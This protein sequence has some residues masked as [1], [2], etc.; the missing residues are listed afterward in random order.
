MAAVSPD[1]H[2][3]GAADVGMA[4]DVPDRAVVLADVRHDV[5]VR[6]ERGS[7]P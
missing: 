6:V 5:F 7:L 2:D 3:L 1:L 4:G